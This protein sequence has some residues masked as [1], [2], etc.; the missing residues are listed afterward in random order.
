[1][2]SLVLWMTNVSQ[3]NLDQIYIPLIIQNAY[4]MI[5]I[6]MVLFID[7]PRREDFVNFKKD[8][9]STRDITTID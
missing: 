9:E 7:F 6:F 2:G 3:A 8:E 5:G 1:M 4:L